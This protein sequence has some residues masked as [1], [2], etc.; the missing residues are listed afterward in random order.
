MRHKNKQLLYV[1]I[2]AFWFGGIVTGVHAGDLWRSATVSP[3]QEQQPMTSNYEPKRRKFQQHDLVTV[4]VQ[5]SV[6]ATSSSSYQ[7]TQDSQLEAELAEWFRLKS[8]DDKTGFELKEALGN[9]TP[10]ADLEAEF[11]VDN[12]GDLQ[13]SSNITAQVTAKIV[14]VM[15]NGNLVIEAHET[16]E[17]NGESEKLTLSAIVRQQDISPNNTVPSS[18]LADLEVS[19]TGEGSISNAVSRGI[20]TRVLQAIWP[21]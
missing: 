15:P 21:F 18:K 16:R 12:Q 3:K 14:Q 9:S 10:S 19:V 8:T 17:I 2:L 1:G 20:L 4:M 11:E 6:S 5:E 7:S 13:R